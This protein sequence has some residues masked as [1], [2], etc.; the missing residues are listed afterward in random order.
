MNE[1]YRWMD[2]LI[3][4][5]GAPKAAEVVEALPWLSEAIDKP[6]AAGNP[7]SASC[8]WHDEL[9]RART[10]LS[11]TEFQRDVALALLRQFREH[12]MPGL[13]PQLD[14]VLSEAQAILKRFDKI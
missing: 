5:V 11:E 13:K 1:Q 10:R 8:Q 12:Y 4:W 9:S 7:I 3:D 14:W 6:M 2:H